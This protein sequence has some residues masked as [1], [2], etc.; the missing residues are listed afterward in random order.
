MPFM[1]NNFSEKF[2]MGIALKM[3][4]VV[5]CNGENIL[6]IGVSNDI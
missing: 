2:L 1:K 4:E 6:E 5:Y 3:E